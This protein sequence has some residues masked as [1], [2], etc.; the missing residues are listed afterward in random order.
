MTGRFQRSKEKIRTDHRIVHGHD[1]LTRNTR[2]DGE[3]VGRSFRNGKNISLEIDVP[4]EGRRVAAPTRTCPVFSCGR[5]VPLTHGQPR[6]SRPA[7]A[8][9]PA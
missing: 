4:D 7:A 2:G 1:P 6:A 8:P 9:R 3:I 5:L